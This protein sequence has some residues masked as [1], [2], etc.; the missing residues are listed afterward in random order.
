MLDGGDVS[1]TASGGA[2]TAR[3]AVLRA[4]GTYGG[5]VDPLIAYMLLD[6]A[7]ADKSAA[8]GYAF[9]VSWSASG[10]TSGSVA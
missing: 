5:L 10:I 1:W 2:L 7:P 3:Y 6:D 9:D 4:V 8:D